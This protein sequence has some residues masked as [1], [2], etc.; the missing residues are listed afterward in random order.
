[1]TPVHFPSANLMVSPPPDERDCEPLPV[2]A[3][4]S[5]QT[6]VWQP[7]ELELARLRAG[8]YVTLTIYSPYQHPLVGIGVADA[9]E[10]ELRSAAAG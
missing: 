9:R 5:V 10:L 2:R 1:M 7:T 8:G 6:T 4:G 3:L